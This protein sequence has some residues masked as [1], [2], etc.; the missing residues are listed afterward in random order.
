MNEAL[1]NNKVQKLAHVSQQ[2][3]GTNSEFATEIGMTAEVESGT[4]VEAAIEEAG[5]EIEM[6][7]ETTEEDQTIEKDEKEVDLQKKSLLLD[8]GYALDSP[9]YMDLNSD[10]IRLNDT[11]ISSGPEFCSSDEESGV[12]EADI[13]LYELGSDLGEEDLD[14]KRPIPKPF[15]G[16]SIKG[17]N[18]PGT[19]A[20]TLRRQEQD[21]LE[22]A[23]AAKKI[24]N[25]TGFFSAVPLARASPSPS[26]SSIPFA[27]SAL[28]QAPSPPPPPSSSSSSGPRIVST[29]E[30]S[31]ESVRYFAEAKEINVLL[32]SKKL[33]RTGGEAWKGQNRRRHELVMRMLLY[34][35]C[36]PSPQ[37][38]RMIASL[39]VA[40]NYGKGPYLAR[41]I[42][43]WEAAW[44]KDKAIPIG[45]KGKIITTLNELC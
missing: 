22:L 19:S 26:P 7:M 11:D 6:E 34:R 16:I 13:D 18:G 9:E 36:N 42:R 25:I 21:R 24:K 37:S 10:L 44:L 5:V 14:F 20:S 15:P 30:P 8:L 43:R 40:N 28:R 31:P 4:A 23:T 29:P 17:R 1:R 27:R 45:I 38:T 32:K 35:A 3:T 2:E 41:Q 33:E 39:A 12:E